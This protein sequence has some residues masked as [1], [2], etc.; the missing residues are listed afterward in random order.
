ML[1]EL[2]LLAAFEL[3]RGNE[4]A[5]ARRLAWAE[6]ATVRAACAAPWQLV[7]RRAL[8]ARL[9][10]HGRAGWRRMNGRDAPELD[11]L[12]LDDFGEVE[13][14]IVDNGR[15][16][17]NYKTNTHQLDDETRTQIADRW[18]DYF[19]RYGYEK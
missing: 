10:A 19:E 13:P 6:V 1:L 8:H 18:S 16:T 9:R 14:N 17:K 11:D 15:E 7:T 12:D 5:V 2:L 4:P 3:A